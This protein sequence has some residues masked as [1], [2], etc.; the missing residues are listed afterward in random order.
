M[1]SA[2]ST[3]QRRFVNSQTKRSLQL[4]SGPDIL[5]FILSLEFLQDIQT[6]FNTNPNSTRKYVLTAL[7]LLGSGALF[8]PSTV[9]YF[10]YSTEES[11]ISI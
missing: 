3:S 10:R 2:N 11:I 6:F 7:L 1:Y 8:S 4:L 5:T 9:G